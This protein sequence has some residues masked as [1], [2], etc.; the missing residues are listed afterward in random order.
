MKHLDFIYS[1]LFP[2]FL[3]CVFLIN[4]LLISHVS[5]IN[6]WTPN[7]SNTFIS[8]HSY[9][10]KSEIIFQIFTSSIFWKIIV[11]LVM[12]VA[13]FIITKQ[14]F[15]LIYIK[16]HI[17]KLFKTEEISSRKT[18]MRNII[19]CVISLMVL[20]FWRITSKIVLFVCKPARRVCGRVV[21]KFMRNEMEGTDMKFV[22]PDRLYHF[23]RKY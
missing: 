12:R 20:A 7:S 14:I 21:L 11:A 22:M 17:V 6:V 5:F 23:Y 15:S 13:I 3:L 2:S 19:V 8:I 4:V 10:R 1:N 9:Y 18:N 16:L